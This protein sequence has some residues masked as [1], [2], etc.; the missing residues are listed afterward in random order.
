MKWKVVVVVQEQQHEQTQHTWFS[1]FARVRQKL[2]ASVKA[3]FTVPQEQPWQ[4]EE[5]ASSNF[6]PALIGPG[7]ARQSEAFPSLPPPSSDGIQQLSKQQ[8]LLPRLPT[9]PQTDALVH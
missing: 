5:E 9:I 8:E 4:E 6:P 7:M 2:S 3:T 1:R